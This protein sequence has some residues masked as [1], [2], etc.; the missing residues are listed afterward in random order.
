M[1]E[2]SSHFDIAAIGMA[3]ALGYLDL[4]HPDLDW[5]SANPQLAGGI[6][7]SQRP[8]MLAMMPKV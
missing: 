6:S 5:R 1:A 4:R 8:S 2:L 7:R 3:C